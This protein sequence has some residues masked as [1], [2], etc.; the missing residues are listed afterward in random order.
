MQNP[1]RAFPIARDKVSRPDLIRPGTRV[2]NVLQLG[3]ALTG[4]LGLDPPIE[5]LFVYNCNPMIAAPEEAFVAEGL[6]REDLFTVV[7][8]QFPT[9]TAL[10][11]DIVLPATTQLEQVDLMYSWGHFYLTW[12]EQAIPPLGEAVPNTELFRRLAKA[13][14]FDDPHFRRSDEEMIRDA[15][16]WNAPAVD[17]ITVDSLRRNGYARLNV[18]SPERRTP[19]A[20]GEFL[21]RSGKCEFKSSLAAAGS[22]VLPHFRQGYRADQSG[23]QVASVPDYIPPRESPLGANPEARYRLSLITPKSHAFLNSGYANMRVQRHAAGEQ[24]AMLHP[25]D[26]HPRGIR[27]GAIVTVFNDRGR[28]T[29][30]AKLTA[31]VMRGVIAIHSGYWR[32]GSKG[33]TAVNVLAAAEVSNIGR[34]PTFSDVA[35]DVAPA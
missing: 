21:T 26:A 19:H 11:A 15:L 28:I 20:N 8:E 23:A 32:A 6:A 27:D 33:N 25:D 22:F 10:Y 34:A 35:V 17:G 31:D 5:A 29:C 4:R 13:M 12:N 2:V 9:D 18:G 1:A 30:N 24:C 3:R 7:S 14:G 16:D